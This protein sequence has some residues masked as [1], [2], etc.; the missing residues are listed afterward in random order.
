MK[1]EKTS[2]AVLVL[3]TAYVSKSFPNIIKRE[4]ALT[5]VDTT[6]L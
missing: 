2:V 3:D 5:C 4:K 6:L 1:S